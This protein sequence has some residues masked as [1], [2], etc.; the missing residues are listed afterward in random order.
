MPIT[1]VFAGVRVEDFGAARAWYERLHGRPPDLVPH[2]SE[3]AWQETDE[4]WLY[5]VAAG[6]MIAAR[7]K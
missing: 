6:R 5:I 2:E 4:G 1:H 7:R 3:A